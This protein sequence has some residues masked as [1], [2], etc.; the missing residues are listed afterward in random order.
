[1]VGRR[2]KMR[3]IGPFHGRHLMI[4]DA[5]PDH[6]SVRGERGPPLIIAG[7]QCAPPSSSAPKS[8]N[9]LFALNLPLDTMQIGWCL[10]WNNMAC[11][12]TVDV[13]LGGPVLSAI[14]YVKPT[15]GGAG[16]GMPRWSG[17]SPFHPQSYVHM[18]E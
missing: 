17:T 12:S 2:L 11:D 1:L 13:L 3:H 6:E 15:P 8:S 18:W 10:G 7:K 4:L 14:R 9:P 5:L 16:G